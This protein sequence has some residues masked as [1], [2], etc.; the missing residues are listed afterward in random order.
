MSRPRKD[1]DKELVELLAKYNI[2]K[3]HLYFQPKSNIYLEYP[4]II[5]NIDDRDTWKANNKKY[6]L[7]KRYSITYITKDPD[8]QLP[9]ELL[10]SFSYCSFD[11]SYVTENLYHSIFS[12]YF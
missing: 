4:C 6:L 8:D 12:I 11:R 5:Y 1:L 9:D 10:G 7:L 3:S 2:P